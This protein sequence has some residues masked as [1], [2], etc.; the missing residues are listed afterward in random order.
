MTRWLPRK[1]QT[2]ATTHVWSSLQLDGVTTGHCSFLVERRQSNG[3]KFREEVYEQWHMSVL[4]QWAVCFGTV[5]HAHHHW[6][7]T[8]VE[9]VGEEP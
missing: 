6:P 9:L 5:V 8:A 3:E 2:S 7:H 4:T 1:E